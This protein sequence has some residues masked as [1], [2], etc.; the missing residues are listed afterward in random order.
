MSKMTD[1]SESIEILHTPMKHN[2]DNI[3]TAFG[4]EKTILP[5]GWLK[6]EGRRPLSVEMIF[7]KDISIMLR[8]GVKIYADVFRPLA[9]DDEPVPAILPW[10]IFGKTGSGI[11]LYPEV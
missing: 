1:V 3:W 8:D 9:S 6:D 11:H 7:E 2:L 5:K 4:H 10:S